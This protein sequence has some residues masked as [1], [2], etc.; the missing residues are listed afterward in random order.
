MKTL[1]AAVLLAVPTVAG[2]HEIWIERDGGGPARIYLGEPAEVLPAGG[3]PEFSN[4][5]AP[6]LVPASNAAQ[7]RKAGYIEVAVPSGD[8]RAWDD[9]TFTPWGDEGKKEG[10]VYYARAG[11]SEAKAALPF[12]IAPRTGDGDAFVVTREGKPV[13]DLEV[14]AISPSK[15]TKKLKTDAAGLITVPVAEKGRYLLTAAVKDEGQTLAG[16]P[17]AVLHRI[18]TTTFVVQ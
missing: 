3:D 18:T 17:L 5:K 6:K 9:T 14:T 1:I 10:V 2:A 13:A 11:R 7:V 15:W 8:V 12:E 4:L 16:Q